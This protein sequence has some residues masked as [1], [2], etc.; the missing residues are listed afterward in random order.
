MTASL[1][2]TISTS[3][4]P[5]ANHRNI[6]TI[7]RP[8]VQLLT[9]TQGLQWYAPF[10]DTPSAGR[11]D[12]M[13]SGCLPR[14]HLRTK[15]H[16]TY[17][18]ANGTQSKSKLG[19]PS[20]PNYRWKLGRIPAGAELATRCLNAPMSGGTCTHGTATPMWKPVGL[21]YREL[22]GD[23]PSGISRGCWPAISQE[24]GSRQYT[25]FRLHL[26]AKNHGTYP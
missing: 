17:P 11:D 4:A 8:L 5:T 1:H 3:T 10:Y 6:S 19:T 9:S 22:R 23:A 2:F 20:E 7:Q 18:Q 26:R 15:N 13:A 25:Y 21:G 16:C 14:P 24:L 12:R